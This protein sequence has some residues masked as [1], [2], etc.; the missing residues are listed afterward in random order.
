MIKNNHYLSLSKASK[1]TGKSKSVIS[2]ALN[3][4][5]LSYFEK[6]SAGYK[7]DPSELYR[8]FPVENTNAVLEHDKEQLRPPINSTDNAFKIKELELKLE[9]M[10]R[11]RDFYQVQCDKSEAEKEDWKKQA[12]T[13]LLQNPDKPVKKRKGFFARLIP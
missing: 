7:I 5:T 13:L 11:E 6:N 1:I 8:V 2:K 12:Q 3:N 9:A 10:K 4:G